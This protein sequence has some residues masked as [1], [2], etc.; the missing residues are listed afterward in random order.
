MVYAFL[1]GVGK[2]IF[3]Q[4]LYGL[5]LLALGMASALVIYNDFS[6]RSWTGLR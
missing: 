3:G 4:V 5:F 2:L 6:R 1:F